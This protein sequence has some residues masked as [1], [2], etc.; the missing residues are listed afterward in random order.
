MVT[1]GHTLKLQ[2]AAAIL[3]LTVVTGAVVRS[4]SA[5]FSDSTANT[6]NS[7]AA[8]DVVIDDDAASALFTV[9]AMQPG[10]VVTRCINVNYT[11]SLDAATKMYGAV[12]AGTG[13]ADYINVEIERGTGSTDAACT[14]FSSTASLWTTAGDGDLGVF[15]S[16]TTDYATGIDNWAVTGGG[17]TDSASYR[18]QVEL[19]ND[20]NAQGLTSTVSLTWEAQA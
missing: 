19:Q 4:S 11:G 3:S 18:I 8:G 15:T 5:A 20:N 17:A 10:D 16:T 7:F 9:P 14:G 13:L 12:T 1:N 6:G 2:I